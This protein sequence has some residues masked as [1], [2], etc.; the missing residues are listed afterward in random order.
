MRGVN[1]DTAHFTGNYPPSG[2][3]DGAT[4]LGYPALDEVLAAEWTPLAGKTD[5]AGDRAN[6]V[7]VSAPDRLVT[8]VRLTIHPDGGVARLRVHGEIVPDPRH[9]GGRV[10][11]AAVRNGGLVES[12]SNM[13]YASPANVLGPGQA[14]V[15]SDGW[16]TARR[17]DDGNDWLVVRLAAPGVLHHAVIDTAR[18]ADSWGAKPDLRSLTCESTPAKCGRPAADAVA[19][20]DLPQCG[21]S[22]WGITAGDAGWRAEGR[23]RVGDHEGLGGEPVERGGP[24][25]QRGRLGG[26]RR[27]LDDAAAGQD[28]LQVG[29]GDRVTE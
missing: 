23:E 21:G 27:G 4:L 29:G 6:L 12:C 18:F 25:T 3:L 24:A 1:I 26:G 10:D 9:L 19:R 13:F 15:M 20:W 8:H 14:R 28:A 5:L 17:R 16:E 22:G 11:L 7:P 2:S